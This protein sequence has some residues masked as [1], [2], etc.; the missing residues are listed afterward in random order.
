MVIASNTGPS[1]IIDRYGR[2]VAAVPR[3]FSDGVALGEIHPGE[4]GT[5][6]TVAGDVICLL[7]SRAFCIALYAVM[8]AHPPGP[9]LAL[10]RCVLV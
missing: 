8:S 1:Q 5:V 10:I 9:R 3:I 6:F 4:S 2:V 7:L